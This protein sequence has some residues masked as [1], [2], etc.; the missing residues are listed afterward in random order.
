M[1]SKLFASALCIFL[2]PLLAAQQIGCAEEP[3]SPELPLRNRYL[4]I[5]SR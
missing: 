2:A 3:T 5:E 1:T 4:R